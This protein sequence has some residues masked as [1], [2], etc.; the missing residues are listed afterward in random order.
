[1][2]RAGKVFIYLFKIFEYRYNYKR[3]KFYCQYTAPAD[4]LCFAYLLHLKKRAH[5]IS[6]LN[7]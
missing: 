4:S 6:E 3:H 7:Y 1:M 5:L 2:M